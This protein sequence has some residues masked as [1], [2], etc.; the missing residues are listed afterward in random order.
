MRSNPVLD[1]TWRITVLSV[2]VVVLAAG[3]AMLALPGP[4]WAA[5]F[6]ALLIL[7]SEFAWARRSLDWARDKARQA[8]EQALSP[9]VRRR[10]Q[11]IAVVA[12]VVVAVAVLVYWRVWGF[13]GP[14]GQWL[15]EYFGR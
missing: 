7:A 6:L 14:V 1:L 11:L 5:I 15:T 10:N 9:E 4:G 13:P 12:A 8:K 3:I 2:G